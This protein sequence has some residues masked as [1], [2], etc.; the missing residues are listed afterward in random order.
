MP[1]NSAAL[2]Q[3]I[4]TFDRRAFRKVKTNISR[5]SDHCL[6]ADVP[7]YR[8]RRTTEKRNEPA[9]TRDNSRICADHIRWKR[10]FA[11]F[12][13]LSNGH[14]PY[15]SRVIAVA[16][17]TAAK[18]TTRS[19]QSFRQTIANKDVKNRQLD[20]K[21]YYSANLLLLKT[22]FE[23]Y[24]KLFLSDYMRLRHYFVALADFC[25]ISHE[26]LQNFTTE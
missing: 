24:I 8:L 6:R 2:Q 23:L 7:L 1:P 19:F 18:P 12:A 9:M 25:K 21:I 22:R 4:E 11:S 13:F 26:I 5:Y 10:P 17:R 15:N 16:I 3:A 14:L 20:K